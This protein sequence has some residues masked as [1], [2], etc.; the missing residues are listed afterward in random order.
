MKRL[1][2]TQQTGTYNK[3]VRIVP[4]YDY[5][6]SS[7]VQYNLI[8]K[9][10]KDFEAKFAHSKITIAEMAERCAMS[11]T[12]FKRKFCGAFNMCKV[13]T[14]DFAIAGHCYAACFG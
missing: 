7:F 3:V 5:C 13:K 10:F 11:P 4:L 8:P 14:N 9:P 6:D 12:A 2:S 1:T